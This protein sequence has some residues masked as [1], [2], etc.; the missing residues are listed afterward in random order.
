METTSPWH[1]DGRDRVQK[2]ATAVDKTSNPLTV[3]AI[4]GSKPAA[5]VEQHLMEQNRKSK[6]FIQGFKEQVV[7]GQDRLYETLAGLKRDL[8]VCSPSI[9][10]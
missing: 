9:Q 7:N 2:L 4:S 5:T 1:T 10:H 3:T 8:S 6:E